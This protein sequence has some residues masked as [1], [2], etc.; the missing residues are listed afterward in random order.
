MF[1]SPPPHFSIEYIVLLSIWSDSLSLARWTLPK[2]TVTRSHAVKRSRIQDFIA[3]R[4]SL[5]RR[6]QG[7]RWDMKRQ[8]HRS[9]P[10]SRRLM[11]ITL[12]CKLA[13]VYFN[14]TTWSLIRWKNSHPC[15]IRREGSPP[16]YLASPCR[17]PERR[18]NALDRSLQ[19]WRSPSRWTWGV[20]QQWRR[21]QDRCRTI[22]TSSLA[23]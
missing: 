18:Q 22:W 14:V 21:R 13:F 1:K 19:L 12:T 11:L 8:K 23:S 2:R 20:H 7:N 17:G 10:V 9:M 15:T 16:G 4:F 5:L 3:R 6:Y